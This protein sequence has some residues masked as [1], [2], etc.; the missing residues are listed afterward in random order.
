MQRPD[1]FDMFDIDPNL[2]ETP[3]SFG[4]P[5][6]DCAEYLKME[7][8]KQAFLSSPSFGDVPQFPWKWDRPSSLYG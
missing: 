6:S 4:F 8:A 7:L 2:G 5:Q 1:V 3:C